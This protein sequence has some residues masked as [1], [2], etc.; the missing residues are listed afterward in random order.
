[1]VSPKP[2]LA[3]IRTLAGEGD[4][5]LYRLIAEGK[6]GFVFLKCLR[7]TLSYAWLRG[8]ISDAETVAFIKGP[9]QLRLF[10]NQKASLE[11]EF[12]KLQA[13][14]SPRANTK[15][16]Q[17][18]LPRFAIRH[19][20]F[21]T[22]YLLLMLVTR[23]ARYLNLFLLH[24][25]AAI[26]I[27]IDRG[28]ASTRNFICYN[29]QPFDVAAIIAALHQ[30]AD[31]RTIVIQHGLVLSEKFYFPA[32]AQEF[33][34]WGELSRVHFQSRAPNGKMVVKG[35]YKD[36]LESKSDIFVMP[37]EGDKNWKILVAPSFKHDEIKELV[38]IAKKTFFPKGKSFDRMA[39]KMHPATKSVWMI[40]LWLLMTARGIVIERAHMEDLSDQYD[41]LFTKHSTSAVD[42]L[43][44]GKPVAFLTLV[45]GATFPSD[46]YGLSISQFKTPLQTGKYDIEHMNESRIKFLKCALNV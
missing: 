39:I 28:F 45:S 25:F 7:T 4:F 34:A 11:A 2:T 38:G 32:N 15:M 36:D 27:S 9:N 12:G 31:C 41:V 18:A 13:Y 19:I 10:Q 16:H 29:D 5:H 46:K 35:R 26:Q 30:R 20:L 40:K 22:Y 6:A 44:R 8:G 43:L 42:F 21:Q 33:W 37:E 24:F 3:L 14:T 1:V 23:R 17:L